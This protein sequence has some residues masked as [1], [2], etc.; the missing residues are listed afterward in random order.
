ML[1]ILLLALAFSIPVRAWDAPGHEEID[2]LALAQ[3]NPKA[4][5]ELTRL[6]AAM[7][8]PARTYTPVTLGCWMD[9]IRFNKDLPD[10]GKFKTWHYIDIGLTNDDPPQPL[11][12][13]AGD[14]QH[15]NVVQGLKRAVAVLKGG[16]DTDITSKAMAAA[17]V[18]HL[19]GDIHQPLHCASKYFMSHGK[20]RDD[21]GGNDE[22]VLNAPPPDPGKPPMNLHNFWDAAYRAKFDEKTG[23]VVIGP[24]G[25]PLPSFLD[26]T[27]Y[28]Y[29]LNDHLNKIDVDA[30]A[31][32]T[33]LIARNFVY[34]NLTATDDKKTCRLST[35]YVNKARL[36]ARSQLQTAA[37]R[38][39]LLLNTTLG[40]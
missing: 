7:S 2:K 25:E 38:L 26:T 6:A 13:A 14:N 16:T 23:N 9:D 39:A 30:W 19:V 34:P 22:Q 4:R 37:D 31:K 21:R 36:I 40:Q 15:V 24:H 12:P 5:A 32:E 11:D 33:N 18:M 17:I 8:T 27:A 29:P 28:P 20:L 1:R 10:Y 35:A 3:L